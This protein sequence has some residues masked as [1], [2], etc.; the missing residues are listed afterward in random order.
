MSAVVSEKAQAIFDRLRTDA[1]KL[2]A[3][4]AL[5]AGLGER[6]VPFMTGKTMQGHLAVYASIAHQGVEDGTE[7][8]YDLMVSDDHGESKAQITVYVNGQPMARSYL[9]YYRPS[10]RWI[11]GSEAAYGYG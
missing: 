9:V 4:L 3:Q 1:A 2:A 8:N 11:D 5:T 6:Q 7:M 10:E